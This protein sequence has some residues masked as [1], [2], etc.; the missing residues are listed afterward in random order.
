MAF[1]VHTRTQ[2]RAD[3]RT[4]PLPRFSCRQ[5]RRWSQNVNRWAGGSR[6]QSARLSPVQRWLTSKQQKKR[7]SGKHAHT[8]HSFHWVMEW[9]VIC[10]AT[11][12]TVGVFESWVFFYFNFHFY[13]WTPL[14]I[15]TVL[16]RTPLIIRT[17]DQKD[18]RTHHD[19]QSEKK[20]TPTQYSNPCHMP[21]TFPNF[22]QNS[23]SPKLKASCS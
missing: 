19:K 3:T 11:T 20:P 2:P 17:L 12:A 8:Q 7:A 5:H 23:S 4:G 1:G 22:I 9:G 18:T 13:F 14:I 10:S 15:R 21:P 6:S 16:S